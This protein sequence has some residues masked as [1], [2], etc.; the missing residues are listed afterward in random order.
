MES[1]FL[2]WN[3]QR[4]RLAHGKGFECYYML[5]L[6]HKMY[7]KHKLFDHPAVSI[8]ETSLCLFTTYWARFISS[9]RQLDV[10][11][12][13]KLV[14]DGRS[15]QRRGSLSLSEHKTY[16]SAGNKWFE[17]NALQVSGFFTCIINFTWTVWAKRKEKIYDTIKYQ[18]TL[19]FK[20]LVD[21]S[22][23]TLRLYKAFRHNIKAQGRKRHIWMSFK[24]NKIK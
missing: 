16:Q 21:A 4:R 22:Q 1:R 14:T 2:E 24:T 13:G 8:Y 3:I 9:L 5:R 19:L 7:T 6:K 23:G 18:V 10:S 11:L 17:R 15:Y 12:I 20:W